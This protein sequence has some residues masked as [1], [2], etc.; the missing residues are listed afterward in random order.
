MIGKTGVVKEGAHIAILNDLGG[1]TELPDATYRVKVIR[2]W[3]DYE[4]GGRC[5]GRLLDATSVEIARL[6]GTT[7]YEP[8]DDLFDPERVFF[9][10]RDFTEVAA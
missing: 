10:Q 4:I 6:T 1:T 7:G 8:K 3:G 5:E 9:A 2:A